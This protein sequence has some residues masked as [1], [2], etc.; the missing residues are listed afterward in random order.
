MI[1]EWILDI[2]IFVLIIELLQKYI[3]NKEPTEDDKL[4]LEHSNPIFLYFILLLMVMGLIW[5]VLTDFISYDYDIMAHLLPIIGFYILVSKGLYI[6][7]VYGPKNWQYVE[8]TKIGFISIIILIII[9]I[10]LYIS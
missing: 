8:K 7:Y 5:S 2:T 4:F 3:F 9:F 10:G 6:R 1:L